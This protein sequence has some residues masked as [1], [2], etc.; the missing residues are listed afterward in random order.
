MTI[1]N[2]YER[3]I[4]LDP[5]NENAKIRAENERRRN[6]G[7]AFWGGENILD[8]YVYIEGPIYHFTGQVKKIAF[9]MIWIADAKKALDND[10]DSITRAEDMG[11]I[12]IPITAVMCLGIKGEVSFYK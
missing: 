10:S 3:E 7:E 6:Q 5:D 2:K 4:A 9:G 1:N 12:S 8:K 11:R